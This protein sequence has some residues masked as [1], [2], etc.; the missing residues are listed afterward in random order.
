MSNPYG[1]GATSPQPS[2]NGAPESAPTQASGYPQQNSSSGF[3]AQSQPQTRQVSQSAPQYGFGTQ[4]QQG[5]QYPH[6]QQGQQYSQ[7]QQVTPQYG[8]GQQSQGQ[9]Y[10]FAQQP[11]SSASYGFNN[12]QDTQQPVGSPSQQSLYDINNQPPYQG[13]YPSMQGQFDNNDKYNT[14]AV[15]GFIFTFIIWPVGLVLSI[16]GRNEINR[17]GGKGKGLTT[18]SFVLCGIDIVATIMFIVMIFTGVL[19]SSTTYVDQPSNYSYSQDSAYHADSAHTIF[20]NENGRVIL[21]Q[22]HERNN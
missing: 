19:G 6:P 13:N 17:D 20:Q 1:W 14:K 16:L 10:G 21:D 18:A 12:G 4:P 15:L 3:S 2:N 11:Q 5:Q 8:F 7:P 9:Q 22:T